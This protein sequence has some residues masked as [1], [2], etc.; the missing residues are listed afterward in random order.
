MPDIENSS[1]VEQKRVLLETIVRTE[2]HFYGDTEHAE[3]GKRIIS[4]LSDLVR[5]ID[6]N[7]KINEADMKDVGLLL[8]NLALYLE[9]VQDDEDCTLL[10][11]Q[12]QGAFG[13][14]DTKI[15]RTFENMRRV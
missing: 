14:D 7:L 13:D 9:V 6:R 11:A 15:V 4:T 10:V 2:D 12:L 1:L 8:R 3:E 5:L